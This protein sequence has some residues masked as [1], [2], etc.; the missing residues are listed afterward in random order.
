M[1]KLELWFEVGRTQLGLMRNVPFHR[2]VK[3]QLKH[4]MKKLRRHFMISCLLDGNFHQ[5]TLGR[6]IEFFLVEPPHA[7]PR[8]Y[9]FAYPSSVWAGTRS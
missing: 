5:T 8:G 7:G 9:G 3:T 4:T 6:G 2:C 1:P